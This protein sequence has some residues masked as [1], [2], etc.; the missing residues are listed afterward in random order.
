MIDFILGSILL[1]L[2]VWLMSESIKLFVMYKSEYVEE[3]KKFDKLHRESQKKDDLVRSLNNI[4]GKVL[5]NKYE[6]EN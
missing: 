5:V 3:K 1:I 4:H 6:D 2:S